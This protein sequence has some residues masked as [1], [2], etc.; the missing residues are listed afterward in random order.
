M[1]IFFADDG[2]VRIILT[3]TEAAQ[4]YPPP[5][6]SP[7]TEGGEAT[8]RTKGRRERKERNGGAARSA[9]LGGCKGR[10]ANGGEGK[11]GRYYRP[12]KEE[13]SD[14]RDRAKEQGE[15]EAAFPIRQAWRIQ[16]GKC[17]M[18]G[19]GE[20][21]KERREREGIEKEDSG[22]IGRKIRKIAFY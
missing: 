12:E 14:A 11:S 15:R 9:N 4:I 22:T 1:N 8:Q 2:I 3:L 21:R 18:K 16:K 10:A 6:P 19:E 17:R 7:Q 5:R 20:E 13:R